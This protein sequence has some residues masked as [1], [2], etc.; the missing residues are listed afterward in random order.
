MNCVWCVVCGVVCVVLYC[1]L[2]CCVV[3]CVTVLCV[4]VLCCGVL[5][6]TVLYLVVLW[7]GVLCVAL[8][9]VDVF[10]TCR[11][12][13][14]TSGRVFI[15]GRPCY[16]EVRSSEIIMQAV[17]MIRSTA[18]LWCSAAVGAAQVA[19]IRTYNSSNRTAMLV[20]VQV[21]MIRRCR[22]VVNTLCW[23]SAVLE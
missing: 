3:L 4:T 20:L 11:M 17:A 14:L 1:V 2:L 22:W 12:A 8:L 6:V 10:P 5:C 21:A 16:Y 18:T 15:S 7:C 19:M 9:C 23:C 13:V